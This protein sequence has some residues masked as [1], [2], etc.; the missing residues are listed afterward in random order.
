MLFN[1]TTVIVAI[2]AECQLLTNGASSFHSATG[3]ELLAALWDTTRGGW[4][5]VERMSPDYVSKHIKGI[6]GFEVEINSMEAAYKLSQNR[7][8]INHQN[9]VHELEKRGDYHSGA[10]AEEMKKRTPKA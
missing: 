10:I 5:R 6:V 8:R 2:A 7:D 9:I 4:I 1:E 3:P